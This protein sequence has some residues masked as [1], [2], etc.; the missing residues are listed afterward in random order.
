MIFNHR[1]GGVVIPLVLIACLLLAGM[2]A[3][4]PANAQESERC[5]DETG[6]CISGRMRAF[7]QQNG[8]L[9]IFGPPISPPQDAVVEGQP[10]LVQWF[11]YHR[12]E[13]HQQ[14]SPP[15]D[16][17]LGRLGAA[18]LER[19][20][21]NWYALPKADGP[22]EGCFFFGQ[23]GQ[24]V[25]GSFL[26]SWQANGIELGQPGT[27]YAESLALFGLPLSDVFEQEIANGITCT[28]QYF[29]RARLQQ[30]PDSPDVRMGAL[31]QTLLAAAQPPQPPVAQRTA[32]SHPRAMAEFQGQLFF[33][34]D[35]G[36][37]GSELWRSDGTEQGT[38]LVKDTLPGPAS[39][40]P[41]AL[42][43]VGETLF[44]TADIEQYGRGAL[45]R[46]DG[47]PEGTM[48]LK[49]VAENDNGEGPWQLTAS[50]SLLFFVANDGVHGL[51]LWKS[52]GTTEGTQMV[53]DIVP[54][55]DGIYPRQNMPM[56]YLPFNL[57]DV[58][59]T[60]FFQAEDL[61]HGAELWK[62]D[63]TAEG[64][65]LVRDLVPGNMSAEYYY[66]TDLN[67]TLLFVARTGQ[68]AYGLWRSDGTGE[69]TQLVRDFSY[70]E[71][72]G[73]SPPVRYYPPISGLT[74]VN[75][76]VYFQVGGSGEGNEAGLWR[77]DGTPE[78]TFR[79][80][81]A[82]GAFVEF[83]DRLYF[84]VPSGEGT[85]AIWQS[86]GTP[87]GTVPLF[88]VNAGDIGM[89]TPAGGLLFFMSDYQSGRPS[90]LWRTDGTADGTRVNKVFAAG[91]AASD[92][93][94]V[95]EAGDMLFFAADDGTFGTELW[96]SDGTDTGVMLVE[97]INTTPPEAPQP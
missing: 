70:A 56:G 76:L 7:W 96:K 50:G 90:H 57:T 10:V 81:D 35:N 60:L 89:L 91:I 3:P 20:G 83:N 52:D 36:T 19:L 63:G 43:P 55:V 54:G 6:Y 79:L 5:F 93:G 14:N 61:A 9:S 92:P 75:N 27:S 85:T 97:D 26:A 41:F 87:E 29:E 39:G 47:T 74:V 38:W 18:E 40:G 45:W 64:T 8:G 25:C 15:Y 72:L 11:R 59:G 22:Q 1:P 86:D 77:S 28:V 32:G 94:T 16:V 82:A 80:T 44:F 23:T 48:L 34:A 2:A 49:D 46:S 24:N 37:S 88:D 68:L 62:S 33:Q 71:P 31:G 78:G 42:T 95:L 66:L 58:N 53:E 12:L 17:L 30:C 73:P 51:E 69:G 4:R 65:Q 21:I 67:G 84:M 13:L